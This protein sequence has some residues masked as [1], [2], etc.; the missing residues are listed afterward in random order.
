MQHISRCL[1]SAAILAA[2]LAQ[3]AHAQGSA[4]YVTT[5]VEVMADAI[6]PG[7]FLLEAYRDASRKQDG[8]LSFNVLQ[9]IGR[10]NRFAI[11]EAW[12]DPVAL[13]AHAKSASTL[14]FRNNLT[15]IETAPYDDRINNALASK[16]GKKQQSPARSMWSRML[17]C[18]LPAKMIA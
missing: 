8:N 3:F 17:M 12:R 16:K 11:I 13:D 14:Q 15:A 10:P 7:V 9:E 4:I 18:F 6:A 1:L 2:T 5:Y